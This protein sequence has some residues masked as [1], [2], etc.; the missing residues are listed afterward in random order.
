[1]SE[2][3]TS[4]PWSRVAERIGVVLWVSFLVASL[5]TGGFFALIDP[6]VFAQE[7]FLPS[8]MDGRPAAYTAGFFFFWLFT[9]ISAVLAVYMLESSSSALIRRDAHE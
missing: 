7:H 2:E 1:M 5:E 8:W 9:Y 3:A 4:G 6:R